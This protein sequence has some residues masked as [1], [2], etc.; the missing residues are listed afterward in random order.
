MPA[1]TA[2]V[3]PVCSLGGIVIP[4][5]V[6][7]AV[8]VVATG[9]IAA[10]V[11]VGVAAGVVIVPAGVVVVAAAAGAVVIAIAIPVVPVASRALWRRRGGWFGLG[12]VLRFVVVHHER[13][14]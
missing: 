7:V 4:V 8:T 14:H 9:P 12:M 13:V 5:P 6:R 11:V 2:D 1:A 3:P 10:A